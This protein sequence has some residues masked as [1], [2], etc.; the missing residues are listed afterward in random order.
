MCGLKI[1]SEHTHTSYLACCFCDSSITSLILWNPA[2]VAVSIR[3]NQTLKRLVT[4]PSLKCYTSSAFPWNSSLSLT[5]PLW[6]EYS[7]FLG[8]RCF[9]RSQRYPFVKQKI[10]ISQD[11]VDQTVTF[12]KTAKKQY[13][14]ASSELFFFFWLTGSSINPFIQH[15]DII[16]SSSVV[17]FFDSVV[18]TWF[19]KNLW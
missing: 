16:Y 2:P 8:N 5:F 19:D 7:Q 3:G 9:W 12:L 14:V 6:V 1:S 10:S 4:K 11:L 18:H 15:Q 17:Q 13:V